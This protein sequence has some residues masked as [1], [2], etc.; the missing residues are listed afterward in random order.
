MALTGWVEEVLANLK[1]FL[2]DHDVETLDFDCPPVKDGVHLATNSQ[3]WRMGDEMTIKVRRKPKEPARPAPKFLIGSTV[4]RSN[5]GRIGR[6]KSLT[7]WSEGADEWEYNVDFGKTTLGL[8]E[9]GLERADSN[10][11]PSDFAPDLEVLAKKHMAD[12]LAKNESRVGI[13]ASDTKPGFDTPP[14]FKI[15]D[16]VRIKKG[17]PVHGCRHGTIA[18]ICRDRNYCDIRLEFDKGSQYDGLMLCTRIENVELDTTHAEPPPGP[19]TTPLPA[20]LFGYPIR[21]AKF[22]P[23]SVAAK[24]QTATTEPNPLL[25]RGGFF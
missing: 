4:R 9:F 19:V 22:L 16:R 20:T 7:G 11:V 24:E 3:R 1:D 21:W 14:A 10:L 25:P 15:G 8:L 6:I 23:E 17:E 12:I 13:F 18:G 2:K 5:D